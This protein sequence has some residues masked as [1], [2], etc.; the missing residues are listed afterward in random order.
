MGY[1]AVIGLEIHCQLNTK[2]KIFCGCSTKFGEATN[3]NICPI[4]TGMPGALPVLNKKAVEYGMRAALALH[5]QIQAQNVFARKNYFYPD[6]PKGYQI[7]Q[8]DRPLAL[9]GWLDI[10]S[11]HGNLRVGITRIHLEEDAGK[12]IHQGAD[13]IQGSD[14]SLVNLNRAC[15]PL[16]EIVS[17]PDMRT[18]EQAR[19]YVESIRS[20]VRYLGI[21]DGNM[22]EGSL[23]CDANISIRP[24]GSQKLGTKVE[25]KNMNSFRS[26]ERAIAI[27]IQ[28][29][30]A[31]VDNGE[32][33]LQ[34]TR[35]F[36]EA[37][38]KTSSMRSKEESHDYRYFPEPDLLPVLISEEWI[39]EVEKDMPMLPAD[40]KKKYVGEWGLSDYDAEVLLQDKET[41]E[42][43]EKT[44]VLGADPKLVC[45]WLMGDIAAYLK[46]NNLALS[47]AKLTPESLKQ[48][49]ELIGSGKISGKIGKS[50][51]DK[52]MDTGE[53]PTK[54]M[55]LEGLTQIENM[56]EVKTI[57]QRIIEANP[58]PR[59][60]YRNGKT[61]TIGFFVGQ[62][63]K[64]T[65]GRA[66]PE[67][68]NKLLQEML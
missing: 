17:E 65:K 32:V 28:R 42:F 27:E 38:G 8:F 58:G 48:L 19:L 16:I 18:P 29:Q 13:R 54:I 20:I 23:R 53:A 36:D 3:K 2:T 24:E 56:D 1:E 43:F 51:L 52:M 59:E 47:S 22:E 21:C 4:C 15:T 67:L 11:Q 49:L 64:E 62:I 68:V 45:N 41:S 26:I 60:Q 14:Y 44:V 9:N 55:E 61:A 40:R 35:H 30:I 46:N 39:H 50:I 37:T 25:V 12:L 10:E 33:I 7:S 31:A 63:M 6:L 57:V 66:K 5:C 34:E